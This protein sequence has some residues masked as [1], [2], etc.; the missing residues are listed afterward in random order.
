MEDGKIPVVPVAPPSLWEGT[1]YTVATRPS[2]RG[3]GAQ[4]NEHPPVTTEP[5]GIGSVDQRETKATVSTGLHIKDHK[6]GYE[7]CHAQH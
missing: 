7:A 5:K 6:Q 3:V 4:E 1:T 2:N